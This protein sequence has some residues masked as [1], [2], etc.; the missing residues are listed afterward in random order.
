MNDVLLLRQHTAYHES[1]VPVLDNTPSE[2]GCVALQV[3]TAERVERHVLDSELVEM[4]WKMTRSLS[5]P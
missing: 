2:T 3:F 4:I 5:G 1:L